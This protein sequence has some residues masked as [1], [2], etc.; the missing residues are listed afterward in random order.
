M[1]KVQL[2][3]HLVTSVMSLKMPLFVGDLSYSQG[4]LFDQFIA[5]GGGAL[6]V[7]NFFGDFTHLEKNPVPSI[8]P[9]PRNGERFKYATVEVE[10]GVECTM[11]YQYSHS[12]GLYPSAAIGRSSSSCGANFTTSERHTEH[13]TPIRVDFG[14]LYHGV[15]YIISCGNK[16]ELKFYH[17]EDTLLSECLNTQTNIPGFEYVLG[18]QD[19]WGDV[20][21]DKCGDGCVHVFPSKNQ[22]HQVKLTSDESGQYLLN[23]THDTNILKSV[24]VAS[25][26]D[27]SEFSHMKQILNIPQLGLY[28]EVLVLISDLTMPDGVVK[29]QFPSVMGAEWGTQRPAWNLILCKEASPFCPVI[30]EHYVG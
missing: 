1:F 20:S 16:Q 7:H 22:E 9:R 3:A 23:V 30:S 14:E 12:H 17:M 18:H 2:L 13:G 8:L 24:H 4:S 25:K 11:E 10:D 26:N 21:Y 15:E 5:P 19:Y 27:P 6:R 28:R 29:L